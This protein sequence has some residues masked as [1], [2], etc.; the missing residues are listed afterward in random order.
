MRD[1]SISRRQLLK[2]AGALG[3]LGAVGVPVTAFAED[4][5]VRLLRWDLINGDFPQG[6]VLAGGQDKAKDEKTGDVLTLTG[7][8]QAAPKK[9]M[10]T[11][12]GTYLHTHNGSVFSQGVYRVT[13]FKSWKSA[14]GTLA[15]QGLVDGIGTL[16]QTIGG[17]LVMNIMATASPSFGGG[18]VEAV[19]GVNCDLGGEFPIVE[20]V[21]VDVLT[22]KFIQSE[23]F[24]L[25]HVLQGGHG[26]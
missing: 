11:G 19:L 17:V 3:V 25:F 23:G 21:T 6:F 15:G 14:G 24:T 10:A 12:G 5:G 18:S 1:L 20:G 26:N 8:G 9:R 7:S 13:G 2:G 4:D 22:F 16:Q